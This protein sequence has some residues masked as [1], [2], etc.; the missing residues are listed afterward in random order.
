ML[1]RICS[2]AILCHLIGCQAKNSPDVQPARSDNIQTPAA[3]NPLPVSFDELDL[4][5]I[6]NMTPVPVDAV[7]HFPQTLKSLDGKR[8]RIRGF[9]MPTFEVTGIKTFVLARD[10][11]LTDF[12]RPVRVDEMISVEPRNPCDY[13]KMKPFD[14]VGTFRIEMEIVENEPVGLYRIQDAEVVVDSTADV[15]FQ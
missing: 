15:K 11:R 3:E 5:K 6:P 1:S 12:G 9:M 13:V 2:V 14:V 10:L 8:I 4:C 7:D